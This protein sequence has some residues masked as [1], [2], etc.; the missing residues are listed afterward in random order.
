MVLKHFVGPWQLLIFSIFYTVGRTLWMGDQPVASQLPA[1]RT[2][3][4]QNK[5]TQISMT[6]VGFEPTIPVLKRAKTVHALDRAA[7]MI[8][9]IVVSPSKY[10]DKLNFA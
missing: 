1:H 10:T 4:R 3:Q 6:Q 5:C 9:H 2:A 8:G 7:A